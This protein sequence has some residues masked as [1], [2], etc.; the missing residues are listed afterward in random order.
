MTG[1]IFENYAPEANS[2]EGFM[3]KGFIQ[4]GNVSAILE[5]FGAIAYRRSSLG[6]YAEFSDYVSI[7]TKSR[8]C[9]FCD[10][11]VMSN[12]ARHNKG[13][14]RIVFTPRLNRF[15]PSFEQLPSGF[16]DDALFRVAGEGHKM[17]ERY[18]RCLRHLKD[19]GFATFRNGTG[20]ELA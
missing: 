2:S 8:Q 17:T 15:M 18:W 19:A 4:H 11:V 10:D 20:Q 5:A 9:L 6:S 7:A 1:A 12:W 13:R 16:S 3:Y 14:L